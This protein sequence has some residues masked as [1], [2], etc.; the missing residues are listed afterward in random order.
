MSMLGLNKSDSQ[1]AQSMITATDNL[2]GFDITSIMGP[3]EGVVEKSFTAISVGSIGMVD[4]GG[5]EEMLFDAKQKLA[6]AASELGANA[7]VVFRYTVIGRNL[8]KS[9]IAYGTAV[10]CQ[11]N[12]AHP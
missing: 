9:V 8:E 1:I 4:G 7:V 12:Q 6:H 3:V 5:L 10:K 11:K 2:I